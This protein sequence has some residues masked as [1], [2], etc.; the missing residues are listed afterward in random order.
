MRRRKEEE[1]KT[2][3]LEAGDGPVAVAVKKSHVRTVHRDRTL[4]RVA[5]G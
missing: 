1:D 4:S 2:T 5:R 3:A